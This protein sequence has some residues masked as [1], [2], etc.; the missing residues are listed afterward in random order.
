M[1]DD[2][3]TLLQRPIPGKLQLEKTGSASED[4][5]IRE[6]LKAEFSSPRFSA[7]IHNYLTQNGLSEKIIFDQKSNSEEDSQKRREI[8]NAARSFI[9]RKP[10]TL[11]HQFPYDVE[12]SRIKIPTRKLGQ[13]LMPCY[14]TWMEITRQTRLLQEAADYLMK[15]DRSSNPACYV[16][17]FISEFHASRI[18]PPV[19]YVTDDS[20]SGYAV[21]EGAVR[22]I[23]YWL[24]RDEVP[25]IEGFLGTSP[26]M[27]VWAKF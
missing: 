23:S 25:F 1:N 11:F 24:L 15:A 8:L 16:R 21:L 7:P 19:I 5:V 12:W 13:I 6:F 22:S 14:H 3:S 2:R 17:N 26:S 9:D 18:Y 20:S 27:G 10:G 4:S